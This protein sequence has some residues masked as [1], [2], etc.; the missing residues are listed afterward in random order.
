MNPEMKIGVEVHVQLATQS[1]L[2][3]S[4]PSHYGA[5]PNTLI[6]PVC[7]GYPGTLP[8]LNKDAVRKAVTLGI[9]L[10]GHIHS[11]S[12]FERKNY[13]YPD[14]PKS[15][16]ITQHDAPLITEAYMDTIEG[17]VH[18]SRIHLEEDSAKII[19]TTNPPS[20]LVDFNRSG[21]PLLEIV[22]QA[23]MSDSMQVLAFL[24]ELRSTL[25]SLGISSCKMEEGALRFDV[26]VSLSLDSGSKG[27]RVEIKN[28][29]SFRFVKESIEYEYQ[30]QTQ[31]LKQGK[32]I[33]SE[34][35]GFDE[36]KRQTRTLRKKNPA[37]EYRYFP[38]P[39][40]GILQISRDEIE[41][42]RRDLALKNTN[43]ANL[44][45]RK[46]P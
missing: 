37:L 15:Y 6:C 22:S 8:V 9:F 39:D 19:R 30:R 20:L 33:L 29:N 4:C 27:E 34:T 35:R 11:V 46:E 13:V 44:P 10:H 7:M 45:E 42:L 12:W 17:R 28:L 23:E 26:N 16:Q 1:K 38:E 18:I 36:K 21:M 3:C 5:D 43:Y 24:K 25:I 2:F 41:S 32:T 31:L 40:M 14:L